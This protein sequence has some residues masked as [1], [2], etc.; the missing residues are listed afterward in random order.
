MLS[1]NMAVGLRRLTWISRAVTRTRSSCA[2]TTNGEVH[3]ETVTYNNVKRCL[4]KWILIS[5]AIEAAMLEDSMTSHK[6]ALYQSTK[7]AYLASVHNRYWNSFCVCDESCSTN[8]YYYPWT[9]FNPCIKLN[10]THLCNFRPIIPSLLS[11]IQFTFPTSSFTCPWLIQLSR[12][13]NTFSF[14]AVLSYNIKT[15]GWIATVNTLAVFTWA[16]ITFRK[17]FRIAIQ[18]VIGIMIST[19]CVHMHC[20]CLPNHDQDLRTAR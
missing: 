4:H 19:T 9:R 18:N 7:H 5:F 14:I 17:T 20:K 10:L 1:S 2:W 12:V 15:Y 6:N 11:I 8:A 13:K 16:R 3:G